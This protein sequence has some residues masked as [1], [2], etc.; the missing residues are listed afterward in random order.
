MF[1]DER[2]NLSPETW[3]IVAMSDTREQQ[4]SLETGEVNMMRIF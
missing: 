3:P 4:A 1:I 2:R